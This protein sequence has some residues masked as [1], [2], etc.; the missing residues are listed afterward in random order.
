MLFFV[1]NINIKIK[2][3]YIYIL[4]NK[5]KQIKCGLIMAVNLK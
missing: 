4:Q 5:E 2:F 3:I 1:I